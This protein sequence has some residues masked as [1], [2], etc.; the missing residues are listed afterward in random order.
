MQQEMEALWKNKTWF[1]VPKN[2]AMNVVGNKWVY[3][4]KR[5]PDGTVQR[6]KARLVAKGFHQR[7]CIDFGET[8]SPIV[9]ASTVRIILTITV[10]K[11][12]EIKQLDINN[13]F[14]NGKMF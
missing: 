1:L 11:S 7:P 13:A 10:A 5:N 4:I 12:W 9:K 14:L 2:Q 8:F 3:R 6:L